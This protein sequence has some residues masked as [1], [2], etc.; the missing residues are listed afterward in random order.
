M[1]SKLENVHAKVGLARHM[2]S[3]VGWTAGCLFSVYIL[4]NSLIMDKPYTILHLMAP[5]LLLL[6]S[7]SSTRRFLILRSRAKDAAKVPPAGA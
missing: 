3:A 5:I 7:I 2:V 1:K 6:A 4:V